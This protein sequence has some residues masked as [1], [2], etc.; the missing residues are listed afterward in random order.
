MSVLLF[1]L[2]GLTVQIVYFLMDKLK[3]A[4]QMHFD[5]NVISNKL[6]WNIRA[7]AKIYF[8]LDGDIKYCTMSGWDYPPHL[9]KNGVIM[10]GENW[11]GFN[12][13]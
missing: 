2:G 8:N 5:T 7:Y 3:P 1:L 4:P 12:G 13:E 9:L 6:D 10:V 11:S